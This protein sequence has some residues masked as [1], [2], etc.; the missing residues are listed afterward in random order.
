MEGL[1]LRALF[2]VKYSRN[3]KRSS[4]FILFAY[5][6][7]SHFL[8]FLAK[9]NINSIIKKYFSVEKMISNVEPKNLQFLKYSSPRPQKKEHL[10]S[11]RGGLNNIRDMHTKHLADTQL[12]TQN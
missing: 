1:S 3:R 4:F 5:F 2:A 9:A 11:F 10:E 8:Q 6:L 12:I 7:S